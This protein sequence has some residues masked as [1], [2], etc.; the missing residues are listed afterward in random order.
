M[1]TL[2]TPADINES[3][4]CSEKDLRLACSGSKRNG[5]TLQAFLLQQPTIPIFIMMSLRAL[6][7]AALVLAVATA[8][9]PSNHHKI[10][11]GVQKTALQFGFLKELGLEKPSWLPDF[12]DKAKEE[13]PAA[14]DAA[15]EEGAEEDAAVEE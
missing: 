15:P 9:A 12:G 10:S 13:P 11:F 2:S 8:F 3:C 4:R 7:A 6:L 5:H 1:R 14:E